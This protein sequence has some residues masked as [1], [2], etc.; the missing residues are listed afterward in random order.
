ME[1]GILE[2]GEIWMSNHLLMVEEILVRKRGIVERLKERRSLRG[3]ILKARSEG[4]RAVIAEVK[5]R[6]LSEGES[7]VGKISH[8]ALTLMLRAL[9]REWSVVGR[10][11]FPCLR[12]RR[13]LAI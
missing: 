2:G 5:R 13:F 1:K 10:V 11:R 4:K 7:E 8:R 3:A 9:R 6:G 12:M